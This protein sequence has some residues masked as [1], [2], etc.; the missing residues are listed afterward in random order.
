MDQKLHLL[1]KNCSKNLQLKVER[2]ILW[3]RTLRHC[4][5]IYDFIVYELSNLRKGERM[6][7]LRSCIAPKE[8]FK[9]HPHRYEKLDSLLSD[10]AKNNETFVV[11]NAN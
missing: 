5:H 9:N 8:D 7:I 2:L 10:A 6:P 1:L 3:L 4:S 11:S